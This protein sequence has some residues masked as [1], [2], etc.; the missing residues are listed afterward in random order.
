MTQSEKE[1]E[2]AAEVLPLGQNSHD[3]RSERSYVPAGQV[4]QLELPVPPVYFPAGQLMQECR[5]WCVA[6]W[7]LPASHS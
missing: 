5:S 3:L 7:Y 1:S 2:P 4:Q 6:D